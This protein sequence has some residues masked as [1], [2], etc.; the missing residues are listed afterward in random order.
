MCAARG[1]FWDRRQALRTL[2]R[3]DFLNLF[4]FLR[5]AI[6]RADQKEDHD[7]QDQEVNNVVDE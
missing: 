6:D 2:A 1:L 7:C 3:G 4:L 5:Q